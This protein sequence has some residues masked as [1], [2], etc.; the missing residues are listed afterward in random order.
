MLMLHKPKCENKDITFNR[1]SPESHLHG[2]KH[3]HKNPFYFSI[4]AVFEADNDKDNSS[5]GNRTTN[6]FKQNPIPNGQYLVSELEDVL[7][8]DYQKSLLVYNNVVWFADEVIKLEN[9]RAFYFKNTNKDIVLTEEDEESF[10]KNIICRFCEKE[11]RD[12]KTRDHCHLTGKNRGPAHSKCKINLTQEQ[13]IFIPFLF[14][15]FSI[16]ACNM[17]FKK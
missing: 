9:K 10:E 2:K 6:I 14:H 7:K 1:T 5:I 11:I 13:S 15:N 3:F 12:D 4:Y 17:F 16:Y 8:S